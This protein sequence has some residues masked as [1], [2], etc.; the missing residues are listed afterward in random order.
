[1][2]MHTRIRTHTHWKAIINIA[3][4]SACYRVL[5]GSEDLQALSAEQL[6]A[7]LDLNSDG[8]VSRPVLCMR[9]RGRYV[10]V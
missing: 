8:H 4:H 1:M 7:M 9:V 6:I 5:G 10:H 2:H 3:F